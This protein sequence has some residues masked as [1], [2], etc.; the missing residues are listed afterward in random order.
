M[1]GDD[2]A[3]HDV[4]IAGESALPARPHTDKSDT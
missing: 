1:M 4:W 3:I 2:R